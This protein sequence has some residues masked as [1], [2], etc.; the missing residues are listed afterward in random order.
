VPVFG[1]VARYRRG[2][3]AGPLLALVISQTLRYGLREGLRVAVAPLISD[4]P[5][6]LSCLFVLSRVSGL[7]PAL[8]WV[9]ILGG[10]FVGYLGFESF[11]A[12]GPDPGEVRTQPRSLSKAVLLN[13]LNPHVYLFWATVG[14]PML[15]KVSAGRTAR[16]LAFAGGFYSCL[17][18]PRFWW[19]FWSAARGRQC[20]GED[21]ASRSARSESC[22]SASRL[23]VRGRCCE[24]DRSG[25]CPSGRQ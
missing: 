6:V 12:S 24:P 13:L 14:G 22:Y 17:V 9:S 16:P 25:W 3:V 21:T 1:I 15:L 20:P 5:V 4:V 18:G 23:D 11:R 2:T 10:V 19:P 8:A 7:G